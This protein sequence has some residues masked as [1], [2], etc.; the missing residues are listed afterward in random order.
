MQS[1]NINKQMAAIKPFLDNTWKKLK[2]TQQEKLKKVNKNF[3]L[4]LM[5]KVFEEYRCIAKQC[6]MNN[7]VLDVGKLDLGRFAEYIFHYHY[8]TVS[9]LNNKQREAI[10]VDENYIEKLA[11]NVGWSIYLDEEAQ[12]SILS[13]TS[14]KSPEVI[15]LM[16]F[17]NR[18]LG[19]K[20]KV[21]NDEK[22]CILKGL[23]QVAI[24]TMKG[25]ANLVGDG[26]TISAIALW[27][28]LFELECTIAILAKQNE[29]VVKKYLEHQKFANYEDDDSIKAQVKKEANKHSVE[30]YREFANYGWLIYCDNFDLKQG[31]HLN[32]RRGVLK[33]AECEDGYKAYSEASKIIHGSSIILTEAIENYYYFSVMQLFEST[34]Y[35]AKLFDGFIK[36]NSLLEESDFKDYDYWIRLLGDMISDTYDIVKKKINIQKNYNFCQK[37]T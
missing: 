34:K 10:K 1:H 21:K 28:N 35:I 9:H 25:V 13:M 14:S 24:F 19:V 6:G 11:K 22:I 16:N 23:F 30:N 29:S 3:V 8:F 7:Q 37:I 5:P 4:N 12:M 32:F 20:L 15:N 27:R 17:Y 31:F 2:Q 18:L 33:L 26:N 36:D